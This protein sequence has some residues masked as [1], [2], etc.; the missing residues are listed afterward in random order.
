MT[1]IAGK[2]KFD[3]DFNPASCQ[4]SISIAQDVSYLSTYKWV[5]IF[6]VNSQVKINDCPLRSLCYV[7]ERVI[8]YSNVKSNFLFLKAYY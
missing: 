3:L 2:A 7:A 1:K 6:V 5:L 8:C 4:F